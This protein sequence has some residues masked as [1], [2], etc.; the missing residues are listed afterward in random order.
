MS[1]DDL[2][3]VFSD[4]WIP[5][6]QRAVRRRRTRVGKKVAELKIPVWE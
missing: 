2:C 1:P 5:F 4:P 6:L 3:V